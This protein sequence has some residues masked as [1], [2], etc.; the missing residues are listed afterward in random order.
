[1]W[2]EHNVATF[3]A[4]GR[5]RDIADIIEDL[6]G[7]FGTM[8]DAQAKATAIQLGF[9]D[10][11]FGFIQSLLDQQDAIRN[12][13]A[14]LQNAGGTMERVAE[15][16]LTP[17]QRK[18][19]EIKALFETFSIE[20]GTPFL[21]AIGLSDTSGLANVL[22]G[23]L[24]VTFAIG[25]TWKS[26]GATIDRIIG[27]FFLFLA[28]TEGFRSEVFK[29][30]SFLGRGAAANSLDFAAK[31]NERF[32]SAD[33]GFS[34]LLKALEEPTPG[35]VFLAKIAAAQKQEQEKTT[36]A[37]R[38]IERNTRNIPLLTAANL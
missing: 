38:L 28:Q 35:E 7:L 14:A 4:D 36:K 21:D 26:I 6:S 27:E 13:E 19:N 12:Y 2:K 17:F 23:V 22:A 10:K 33:E 37:L 29:S 3:D 31:A 25:Q 30:D 5:M 1:M 16:Q 20:A 34:D 11:S 24:D 15:A 18:L 9:T 8:S 32:A